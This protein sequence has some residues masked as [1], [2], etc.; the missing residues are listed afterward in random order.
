[1]LFGR[2]AVGLVAGPV[3]R[4][5]ATATAIDTLWGVFAVV[6][7]ASMVASETSSIL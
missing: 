7:I 3:A 2:I 4:S 5:P 6:G 1:M